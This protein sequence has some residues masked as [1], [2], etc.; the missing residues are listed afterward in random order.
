[1]RV[2]CGRSDLLAALRAV[3]GVAS[4]RA[5]FMPVLGGVRLSASEGGLELAGTDLESS[6]RRTVAVE[7]D[8]P[9]AAL[10]AARLLVDIVGGASGEEV[11]LSMEDGASRLV[12]A[13]GRSR[14]EVDCMPVGDFPKVA[15]ASG[16]VVYDGPAEAVLSAIR[17]VAP[18]ASK[19]VSRPVLAGVLASFS[20]GNA[21]ELVATDQ[22]RLCVSGRREASARSALV[23]RQSMEALAGLARGAESLRISLSPGMAVFEFGDSV[24]VTRLIDGQ[25]PEWRQLVPQEW[26]H[27]IAV[28]RAELAGVVGRVGVMAQNGAPLRLSFSEGRVVVEARTPGVGEAAEDLAVPYAGDSME[29]GLR[30]EFVLDALAGAG[31]PEVRLRMNGPGAMVVVE[32]EAAGYSSL[33]MPMRLS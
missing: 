22:A 15:D 1:M 11:S 8:E 31:S 19:D 32:D 29:V 25:F 23:P 9:G 10:P 21:F 3:N 4:G 12:V 27:D 33:M 7:V 30:K 6:L 5:D 13:S 2:R 26:A 17:S 20:E 14:F 16:D 18:A 24:Y 28:D